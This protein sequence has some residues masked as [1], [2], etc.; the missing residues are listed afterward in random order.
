MSRL[1]SKLARLQQDFLKAETEEE[2][3][4]IQ[5]EIWEI[6][7]EIEQE[8]SGKYDIDEDS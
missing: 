6:E 3:E 8:E 2:R 5:D 4:Q 7:E 1:Y